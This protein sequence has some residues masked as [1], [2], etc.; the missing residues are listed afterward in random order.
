MRAIKI[1]LQYPLGSDKDRVQKREFQIHRRVTGHDNI[2]SIHGF[3]RDLEFVYAVMDFCAGGDLFAAITEKH[4]YEDKP[5]RIKSTYLQ[6]LDG[7]QHCHNLGIYHRD[8]KPENIL[9]SQNG[10]RIRLADFGLST[11]KTFSNEFGCGSSYYMS[12]ECIGTSREN[13]RHAYSTP[14]NDIWSLGVILT[15]MATGRNPWRILKSIFV[16]DWRERIP[17]PQ[18][19][20]RM[21]E[22]G[23]VFQ[24]QTTPLQQE[25]LPIA[26]IQSEGP[27]LVETIPPAKA[28][29]RDSRQASPENK[30][31]DDPSVANVGNADSGSP[32]R[33]KRS[34]QLRPQVS[35]DPPPSGALDPS[36]A[37]PS[38]S[39]G[40]SCSDRSK[41]PKT[42]ASAIKPANDVVEIPGEVPDLRLDN[43]ANPIVQE[44]IQPFGSPGGEKAK[45]SLKKSN[46]FRTL[47]RFRVGQ[48]ESSN[49][50]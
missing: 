2:V 41:G 9:C 29:S 4:W 22:L 14:H 3:F 45:R 42:P 17:L 18:L 37:P 25:S 10:S 34:R 23:K 32:V 33:S 47:Q 16:L 27:T 36:L 43:P 28:N 44:E 13:G 20:Q 24:N 46:L 12:P 19:R 21:V 26:S 40:S 31:L 7:V 1:L 8:I 15:N 11:N 50:E 5:K 49:P 48:P 38:E 39:S 6:I 30:P 35:S